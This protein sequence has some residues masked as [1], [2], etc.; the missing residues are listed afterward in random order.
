MILEKGDGLVG[1][2]VTLT[3]THM[4][5]HGAQGGAPGYPDTLVIM[6]WGTHEGLT[7]PS[8]VEQQG[9]P[10]SKSMWGRGTVPRP[11]QLGPVAEG[12]S[13]AGG[14]GSGAMKPQGSHQQRD[15][16]DQ[17]MAQIG[18][19]LIHRWPR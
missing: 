15:Q 10:R 16:V 2:I 4:E 9:T 7:I 12:P 3:G 1:D 5:T 6:E 13:M 18:R 8:M 11:P 19:N 17:R 14:L